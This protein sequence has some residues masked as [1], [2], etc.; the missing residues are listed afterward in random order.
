M[1]GTKAYLGKE[2]WMTMLLG[3]LQ[4]PKSCSLDVTKTNALLIMGG[5]CS[6]RII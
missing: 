3:A 2:V 6:Q 4:S 1:E 5:Q